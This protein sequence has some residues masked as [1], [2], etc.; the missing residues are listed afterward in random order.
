[1][2]E[3]PMGIRATI[4]TIDRSSSPNDASP[5]HKHG[6]IKSLPPE[7]CSKPLYKIYF[8]R[9]IC[10][11]MGSSF[12]S[13]FRNTFAA[14]ALAFADG[15]TFASFCKP[16][17]SFRKQFVPSS[18]SFATAWLSRLAFGADRD[19][20]RRGRPLESVDFDG[21]EIDPCGKQGSTRSQFP[22][23]RMVLTCHQIPKGPS[24]SSTWFDR[25]RNLEPC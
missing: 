10:I 13:S 21:S 1:M 19:E 2:K 25:L 24:S 18:E 9:N 8:I 4:A 17:P 12:A 20:R 23:T 5:L 22:G 16:F 15:T 3:V 11:C 7:H 6:A 14:C